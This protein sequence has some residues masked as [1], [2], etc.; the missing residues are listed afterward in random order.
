MHL[1]HGFSQCLGQ[2]LLPEGPGFY[3]HN[4]ACSPRRICAVYAVDP[5]VRFLADI[6]SIVPTATSITRST[7]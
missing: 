2:N 1:P 7:D 3:V 6:T 5:S 4:N